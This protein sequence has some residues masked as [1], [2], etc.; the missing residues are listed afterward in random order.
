ML[1][2]NRKDI[3]SYNNYS[4]HTNNYQLINYSYPAHSL[5]EA[6]TIQDILTP[7]TVAI[8]ELLSKEESLLGRERPNPLSTDIRAFLVKVGQELTRVGGVSS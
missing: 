6:G 1:H 4:A 2:E 8:P 7:P 5:D 3:N